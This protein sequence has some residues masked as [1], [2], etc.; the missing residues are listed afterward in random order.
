MSDGHFIFFIMIFFFVIAS[1]QGEL[2]EKNRLP[3][4]V[5]FKPLIHHTRQ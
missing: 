5:I 1:T 4:N 3:S 2:R